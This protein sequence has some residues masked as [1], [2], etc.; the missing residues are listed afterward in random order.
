VSPNN[1]VTNNSA[2]NPAICGPLPAAPEQQIGINAPVESEGVITAVS[3]DTLSIDAG[4]E[5]V[6]FVAV[7]IDLTQ[8]FSVTELVF[9]FAEE[10]VS[11]GPITTVDRIGFVEGESNFVDYVA[12]V[13]FG[14]GQL[15][16][17]NTTTYYGLRTTIAS[18]PERFEC[19]EETKCGLQPRIQ[20]SYNVLL[21]GAE[22]TVGQLREIGSDYEAYLHAASSLEYQEIDGEDCFEQ[23]SVT[24]S[25]TLF[26][27][28]SF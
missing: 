8:Y 12:T 17:S 26:T 18:E 3:R 19:V 14:E 15:D 7:G 6:E 20:T 9:V 23:G 13:Q 4:G 10:N 22:L 24:G 27:A 2:N 28:G 25:L 1:V 5:P 21:D 11:E 16:L